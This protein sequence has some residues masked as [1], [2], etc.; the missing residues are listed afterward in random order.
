M[1]LSGWARDLKADESSWTGTIEHTLLPL[2]TIFFIQ[3]IWC[4]STRPPHLLEGL[5]WCVLPIKPSRLICYF[6]LTC[7]FTLQ[8]TLMKDPVTLPSSKVT[9]DRP[10]IIRHLLSDSVSTVM[11]LNY[12]YKLSFSAM[13]WYLASVVYII[14]QTDPFNRSHLTQDMLIPN[15]ELKLQ[16]EEFVRSQQSRKRS[17]AV[18][19]IGEADGADD[20]AE[21]IVPGAA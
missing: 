6:L 4:L 14:L 3:T 10:V 15:T 20:M 1:V 19:E 21:W 16:I 8:Y 11:S 2:G 18:S 7:D 17:A 12:R 13:L 9:V 5:S